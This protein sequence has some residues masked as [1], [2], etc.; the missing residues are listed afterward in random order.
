MADFKITMASTR[1]NEGGY[2]SDAGGT[3]AGITKK[4][5]PNWPGFARIRE[6]QVKQFGGRPIPRYTI[7]NDAV[8]E[9]MVTDFYK[10]QFW[11]PKLN[12][13]KI[14]NQTIADFLY[15]FILHKEGDAVTIINNTAKLLR[16]TVKTNRYSVSDDVVA[17]I[18]G[19]S[20]IFYATVWAA[21]INYYLSGRTLRGDQRFGKPNIAQFVARTKTFPPALTNVS[22]IAGIGS[23]LSETALLPK[24]IAEEVAVNF[25]GQDYNTLAKFLA[26]KANR[27]FNTNP[28]FNQLIKSRGNKGRD[29]LYAFMQHWAQAKISEGIAGIGSFTQ[30]SVKEILLQSG[31][32]TPTKDAVVAYSNVSKIVDSIVTQFPDAKLKQEKGHAIITYNKGRGMSKIALFPGVEKII[33]QS[34]FEA[35]Y[36]NA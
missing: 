36:R 28:R 4:Y 30:K 23:I 24:I 13:D 3:Y 7:F 8:L 12:G 20:K 14:N 10:Q 17:V 6:L 9:Q 16:P 21:R 26:A 29:A 18:N 32:N 2:W 31:F 35:K 19:S 22:G 27:L 11:T 25:P 15:D 33:N 5:Y 1:K 34:F